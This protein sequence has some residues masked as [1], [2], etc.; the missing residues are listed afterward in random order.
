[1]ESADEA[2]DGPVEVTLRGGV[3]GASGATA[4][5][6]RAQ[7]AKRPKTELLAGSRALIPPCV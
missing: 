3:T 5:V 7:I 2:E 4:C 1:M 6:S